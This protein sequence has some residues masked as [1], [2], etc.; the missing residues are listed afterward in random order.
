MR[1]GTALA[2]L[3]RV[4]TDERA[5]ARGRWSVGEAMLVFWTGSAGVFLG[6]GLLYGAIRVVSVVVGRVVSRVAP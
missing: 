5:W 2:F 4:G 6:M 1:R 3:L